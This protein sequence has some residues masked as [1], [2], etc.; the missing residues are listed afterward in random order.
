MEPPLSPRSSDDCPFDV[1]DEQMM[2]PQG[3]CWVNSV[4]IAGD[5]LLRH[6]ALGETEGDRLSKSHSTD[7]LTSTD[8]QKA[9]QLIEADFNVSMTHRKRPDF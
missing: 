8:D 2:E 7:F 4:P 6:F 1:D 9:W 5:S 3:F